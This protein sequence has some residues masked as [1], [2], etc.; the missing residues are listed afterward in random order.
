M[1]FMMNNLKICTLPVRFISVSWGYLYVF[2]QASE[3][4]YVPLI[5]NK[6]GETFRYVPPPSTLIKIRCYY[7]F[8]VNSR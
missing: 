1:I 5:L 2:G 4:A 7:I 8:F 6:K 3:T